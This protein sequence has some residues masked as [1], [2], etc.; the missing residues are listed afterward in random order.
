MIQM[1]CR[2]R[3]NGF[4]RP[5]QHEAG[6]SSLAIQEANAIFGNVEE[7]LARREKDLKRAAAIS[8][9]SR[10]NTLEDEFEPRIL[11]EKYMTS[12]DEE[13]RRTDVP[14]RIQVNTS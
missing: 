12:K 6:V 7:L 9:E 10:W 5:V 2:R 3:S 8:S 4:E 14:E 11:A 1:L 13:I